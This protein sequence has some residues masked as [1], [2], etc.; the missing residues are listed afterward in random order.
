MKQHETLT[1]SP[2]ATALRALCRL[3]IEH[4]RWPTPPAAWAHAFKA[5]AAVSE[6]SDPVKSTPEGRMGAA[7]ARLLIGLL[8]R[9]FRD[10]TDHRPLRAFV[11]LVRDRSAL[12]DKAF[13]VASAQLLDG[14]ERSG[15]DGAVN[16]FE[17]IRE[18][19]TGR[20]LRGLTGG[21]GE[22]A[23]DEDR[24]D[25]AGDL[26]NP[27]ELADTLE[28][29]RTGILDRVADMVRGRDPALRLMDR[30][31]IAVPLAE[32]VAELRGTGGAAPSDL[33]VR[34]TD[35]TVMEVLERLGPDLVPDPG[36]KPFLENPVPRGRGRP[37]LRRPTPPKELNP[38][39]ILQQVGLRSRPLGDSLT[40]IRDHVRSVLSGEIVPMGRRRLPSPENV[41]ALAR[42]LR[43]IQTGA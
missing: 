38:Y 11:P 41:D 39:L 22:D 5:A 23:A 35:R 43:R 34:L 31:A 29:M 27:Y 36:P 4:A 17:L 14:P 7:C 15:P 9:A 10:V 6:L 16:L 26:R 21:I 19:R 37:P 40:R 32:A 20:M 28:R 25:L 12:V 30:L 8:D 2:D 24:P 3:L 33:R 1:D 42:T 18:D 13:V